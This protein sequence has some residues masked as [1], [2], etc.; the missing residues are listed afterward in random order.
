MTVM[1]R[2][3]RKINIVIKVMEIK[4]ESIAKDETEEVLN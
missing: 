2:K 3:G 1:A 4:D